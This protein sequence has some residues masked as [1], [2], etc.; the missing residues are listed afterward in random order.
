[1]KRTT[2]RS[3]NLASVGYDILSAVLE[4]EFNSGAVYMYERVPQRVYK[5]LMA[6]PS[7]GKYFA[8]HIKNKY[9]YARVK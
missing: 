5:E 6:A 8:Q 2:V 9:P 4:I 3:S 7:H 1:M